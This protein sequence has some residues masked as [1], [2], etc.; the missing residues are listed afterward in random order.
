V[1]IAGGLVLLGVAA[2]AVVA[3]LFHGPVLL[4]LS[5][6]HGID[7]GDLIALPFA[8]LGIW[9]LQGTPLAVAMLRWEEKLQRRVRDPI[10]FALLA[11]G[12]GLVLVY[13]FGDIAAS[14]TIA[15]AGALPVLIVAVS[16][17]M[18]GLLLSA[19]G[20]AVDVFGLP[21]WALLVILIA[22]LLVDATDGASGAVVGPTLLA[23]ALS[24]TLG[25]RRAAAAWTFALTTVVFVVL[26]LQS[27]VDVRFLEPQREL[28]GG[29]ASRTAALGVILLLVGILRLTDRSSSRPA[30]DRN[31]PGWRKAV[32]RS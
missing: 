22:G 4:S 8:L 7:L 27:L 19:P 9:M 26:D 24:L 30:I 2:L 13:V 29:G 21:I 31:P 12:T 10:S 32:A 16:A 25:R 11:C 18:L 6:T 14:D 23:A 5:G 1:A 20:A 15:H 28:N 3:P 17:L